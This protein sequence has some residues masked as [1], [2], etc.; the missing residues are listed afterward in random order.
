MASKKVGGIHLLSAAIGLLVGFII[1]GGY[2]GYRSRSKPAAIYISPPAPT[3]VPSATATAEPVTVFVSGQVNKPGVYD[4]PRDSIV[5]EAIEGAGGFGPNADADQVNLAQP[6]NDGLHIHVPEVDQDSEVPV[7]SGETYPSD[8]G[9][10]KINI[11]TAGVDELDTLPGIGPVTAAKIIGHREANGLFSSVAD[12][13]DVDG[14]GPGKFDD[15]KD[16]ISTD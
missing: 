6:L 7:F 13:M 10:S 2:I 5:Q 1:L 11:N 16:L 8:N 15:I 14:I 4:F 12:I 3:N 9:K